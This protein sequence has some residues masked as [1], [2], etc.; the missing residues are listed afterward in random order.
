MQPEKTK[1]VTC[2][3]EQAHLQVHVNFTGPVI[4]EACTCF[5]PG[6]EVAIT[7]E[8]KLGFFSGN[9]SGHYFR[10]EVAFFR[11]MEWSLLSVES[12][13][14]TASCLTLSLTKH[15]KTELQSFDCE[16]RPVLIPSS[17]VVQ[18]LNSHV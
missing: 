17:E 14:S 12:Q 6:I 16:Q 3:N 4:T 10:I 2:K 15:P 8:L 9:R 11:E 18:C 1:L 13:L 5:F 7:F